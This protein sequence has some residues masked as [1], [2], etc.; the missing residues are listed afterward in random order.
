MQ[1]L[2]LESLQFDETKCAVKQGPNI[3]VF[4][5]WIII[6]SIDKLMNIDLIK[7]LYILTK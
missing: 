7:Q 1:Y 5:F 3:V 4:N 2:C 6:Q